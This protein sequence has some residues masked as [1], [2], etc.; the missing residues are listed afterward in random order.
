MEEIVAATEIRVHADR[1]WSHLSD[2]SSSSRIRSDEIV[3]H[4]ISPIHVHP[5]T[6]CRKFPLA[7]AIFAPQTHRE[8]GDGQTQPND[9]CRILRNNV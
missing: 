4:S 9:Y 5:N 7:S 1:P 3:T 8:Y 6:P 2:P